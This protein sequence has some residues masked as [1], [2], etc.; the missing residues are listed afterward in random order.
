LINF[1]KKGQR[2]EK[3]KLN[4]RNYTYALW[5]KDQKIAHMRINLYGSHPF[6]IEKRESKTHGVFF[7]NSNAMDFTLKPFSIIH[8]TIG[9]ILDLYVFI[10]PTPKETIKQYHNLIG[11]PY[12]V[13]YWSLG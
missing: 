8:R 3:F 12:L 2:N 7:R 9:G 10:G 4:T 1:N 5:N 13:S 11:N 6:Y